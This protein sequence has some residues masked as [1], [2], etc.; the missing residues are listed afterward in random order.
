MGSALGEGG[1]FNL[2]VVEGGRS[3]RDSD[4]ER[5][6]L[7]MVVDDEEISREL[8]ATVVKQLDYPFIQVHEFAE[9]AAAL[10]FARDHAVD[11]GLIDLHL[12]RDSMDGLELVVRI[13]RGTANGADFSA[14]LITADTEPMVIYEATRHG[15]AAVM[16]KAVNLYELALRCCALL[17][18]PPPKD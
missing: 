12:G 18:I 8:L 14:I 10:S 6:R 9:P 1:R 15:V 7:V 16:E 5:R 17:R 4:D 13:R 11:L 3:G 2:R